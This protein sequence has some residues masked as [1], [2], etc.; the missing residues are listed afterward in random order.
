MTQPVKISGV[1]I[2]YNEEK[3]IGQCL[4]S[5]A[6]VADEIIVVDSYSKDRTL[7]MCRDY[8]AKITQRAFEGYIEQKNYAASLANCDYILSLDADEVL[9]DEMKQ[10]ILK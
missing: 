3:K 2:T 5:L 1:V 6:E 10:E 4:G 8:N 7:D 9:S